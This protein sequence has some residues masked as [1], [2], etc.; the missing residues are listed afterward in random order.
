LT[1]GCQA[2]EVEVDLETGQITVLRLISAQDA[3]RIVN[4]DTARGQIEA[5]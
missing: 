4:P 3:G 5:P 1:F 2:A